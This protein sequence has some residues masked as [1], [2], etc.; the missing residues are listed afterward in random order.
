[1]RISN[2][3][4]EKLWRRR[5]GNRTEITNFDQVKPAILAAVRKNADIWKN[6]QN[7]PYVCEVC[8]YMIADLKPFQIYSFDN[9]YRHLSKQLKTGKVYLDNIEENVTKRCQFKIVCDECR[10][11]VIKFTEQ[12]KVEL[13]PVFRSDLSEELLPYYEKAPFWTC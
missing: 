12:T 13:V 11:N 10:Q 1:M 6:Q 3:S 9:S 2:L 8:N 4:D 7:T 5:P